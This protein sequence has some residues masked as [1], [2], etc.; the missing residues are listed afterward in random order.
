MSRKLARLFVVTVALATLGVLANAPSV[1][2]YGSNTQWQVGFSGTCS[3]QSSCPFGPA[4]QIG[5]S[6]F[7]GWCAFGASVPDGMSGT[8]ADCQLTTY[9]GPDST[10]H[11]T[12]DITHWFIAT[13][14]LFLP[15]GVPG[16]FVTPGAGTLEITGPGPVPPFVPKGVPFPIPNP[17]PTFICDLGIPAVAGH[18]SLHPS[19]GVELNIQVTKLP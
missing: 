12:Y 2:A 7:W 18:V 15:P 10:L 16:F 5:A 3:S 6:G 13:G 14:S 4:P 8:A 19:P 1:L 9:G 11:V 17:C